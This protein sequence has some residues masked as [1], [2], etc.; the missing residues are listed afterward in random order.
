M[1]LSR[2]TNPGD[3]RVGWRKLRG[4][5]LLTRRYTLKN[6]SQQPHWFIQLTDGA[7]G[8]LPGEALFDALQGH[9]SIASRRPRIPSS[10]LPRGC[11]V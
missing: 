1:L 6:D 7:L 10:F 3:I 4:E 5:K 9:S 8:W 2:M 11:N